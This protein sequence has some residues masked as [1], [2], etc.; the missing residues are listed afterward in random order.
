MSNKLFEYLRAAAT[1]I[2]SIADRAGACNSIVSSTSCEPT[3]RTITIHK[4]ATLPRSLSRPGTALDSPFVI[5]LAT[6]VF[7][8]G[9]VTS[10]DLCDNGSNSQLLPADLPRPPPEMSTTSGSSTPTPWLRQAK[11]ADDW[12]KREYERL[13]NGNRR[14]PRSQHRPHLLGE[15]GRA[16]LFLLIMLAD[17]ATYCRDLRHDTEHHMVSQSCP[18]LAIVRS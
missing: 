4:D 7:A 18:M 13:I 1:A 15:N 11:V 6:A 5:T 8:L 16:R 3:G 10:L 2:G 17:R 9:P 12:M 14:D